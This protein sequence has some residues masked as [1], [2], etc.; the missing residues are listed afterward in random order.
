MRKSTFVM[1]IFSIVIL[2]CSDDKKDN[3]QTIRLEQTN[4]GGKMVTTALNE[5]LEYKAGISFYTSNSGFYDLLSIS[6]EETPLKSDFKYSI[7]DQMLHI[8]GNSFLKG[9]WFITKYDEEN[10]VLEQGTGGDILKTV[11][12]L[13]KVN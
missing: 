6:N 13:S 1:L 11:L 4:W 8:E 2:S 7:D 3:L 12:T 10:L 5:V 9:Y